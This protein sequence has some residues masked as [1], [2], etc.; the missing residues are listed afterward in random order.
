MIHTLILQ[1]LASATSLQQQQQLQEAQ[2][3]R[4]AHAAASG[5]SAEHLSDGLLSK[6]MSF[7]GGKPAGSNAAAAPSP[8][9]LSPLW[10]GN[11]AGSAGQ[12][13]ATGGGAKPR[14]PLIEELPEA[15][16]T[17]AQPTEVLAVP[18]TLPDT[19]IQVRKACE[20][21]DIQQ[22]SGFFST[23]V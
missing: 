6:L 15:Q 22:L 23:M 20:A 14:G 8:S 3:L 5:T 19:C 2:K 21:A 9:G 16:P 17:E 13:K 7:G 10:S 4:Q 11:T 12:Q 1:V 18:A